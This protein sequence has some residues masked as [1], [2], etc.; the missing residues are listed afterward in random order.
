MVKNLSIVFW[1]A[2][3]YGQMA[4]AQR[5]KNLIDPLTEKENISIYNLVRNEKA[6]SINDTNLKVNIKILT[7]S[8]KKPWTIFIFLISAFLYLLKV[9]KKDRINIFYCYSYPNM[10]NIYLL[11]FSHVLGY[12]IV[13]DIVEDN[14]QVDLTKNSWMMKLYIFSSIKMNWFIKHW[15]SACFAISK[16]LVTLCKKICVEKVPVYLLPISVDV[17]KIESYKNIGNEESDIVVFYGGSF[18][19]KDGINF[20]IEGFEKAFL[21]CPKIKLVLTGKVSRQLENEFDFLIQKSLAKS[22][23]SYLGCLPNE[24]FFST[25]VNSDL[26]CMVR[27][28]TEYANAGFPFKLGEYLASG[29]PVIATKVGDVEEYLTHKKNAYLIQAESAEEIAQAI[30]ELVKNKEMRN[31]IGNNGKEICNKYFNNRTIAEYL[32]QTI[33]KTI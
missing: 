26:L 9:R 3:Y 33:I 6:P 17:D 24:E 8:V 18:G 12:K 11:F 31:F 21:A 25:M 22:R 16:N 5:I 2:N 7:Y 15:G 14:S 28:N 13:F 4:D 1:G 19:Y 30:I 29:N 10:E 23:I 27:V 20:L 32:Y